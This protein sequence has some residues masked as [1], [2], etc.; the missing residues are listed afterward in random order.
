MSNEWSDHKKKWVTETVDKWIGSGIKTDREDLEEQAG[1]SY[2]S[3]EAV[4]AEVN[5]FK[6]AQEQ[7]G[8]ACNMDDPECLTCGS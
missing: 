8:D 7:E 3:N 1:K 6:E 2:D 4:Q 5:S